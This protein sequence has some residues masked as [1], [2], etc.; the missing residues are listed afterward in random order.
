MEKDGILVL[1]LYVS[2]VIENYI[3]KK[4]HALNTKTEIKMN[5]KLVGGQFKQQQ[6]Y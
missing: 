1:P 6:K 2:H 5:L 4:E 3:L